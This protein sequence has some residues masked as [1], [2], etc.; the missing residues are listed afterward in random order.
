LAGNRNNPTTSSLSQKTEQRS[1]TKEHNNRHQ[2][3]SKLSNSND[4]SRG[5]SDPRNTDVAGSS[6]V[7]VVVDATTL[8]L[9][10]KQHDNHKNLSPSF[11]RNFKRNGPT[12]A[13]NSHQQ[14]NQQQQQQQQQQQNYNSNRHTTATSTSSPKQTLISASSATVFGNKTKNNVGHKASQIKRIQLSTAA[15]R[16]KSITR[17]KSN[18]AATDDNDDVNGEGNDDDDDNNPETIHLDDI[19]IE[20]DC[21]KIAS[22]QQHEVDDTTNAIVDASI[23]TQSYTESPTLVRVKIWSTDSMVVLPSQNVIF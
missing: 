1:T 2:N 19:A 23:S 15:K 7:G 5:H 9:A 4:P 16:C 17:A 18:A 13:N 3:N 20:D 6:S 8:A 11:R 14:Y 12:I 21:A 22:Q 10:A